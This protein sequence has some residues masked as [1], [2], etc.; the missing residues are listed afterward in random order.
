VP[1]ILCQPLAGLHA[2]GLDQTGLP[3]EPMDTI[4]EM[5]AGVPTTSERLAVLRRYPPCRSRET[6]A[7][8][9]FYMSLPAATSPTSVA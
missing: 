2:A 8:G 7:P 9:T 4:T 6:R 3:F 1:P 5:P